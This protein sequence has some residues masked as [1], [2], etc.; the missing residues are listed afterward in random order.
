MDLVGW[1]RGLRERTLRMNHPSAER[2]RRVRIGMDSDS[3]DKAYHEHHEDEALD[4]QQHRSGEGA[5]SALASMKKRL[6]Q[7]RRDAGTTGEDRARGGPS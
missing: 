3:Q 5:A 1:F 6:K 4:G 2:K 7:L